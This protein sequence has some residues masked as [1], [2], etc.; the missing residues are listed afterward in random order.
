MQNYKAN[1]LYFGIALPHPVKIPYI[2]Q[3]VAYI[4]QNAAKLIDPGL[5]FSLY[6]EPR[7]AMSPLLSAMKTASVE[8]DA[9]ENLALERIIKDEE[10]SRIVEK[11][12]G[13]S[14]RWKGSD[15]LIEEWGAFENSA[16]RQKYYRKERDE[17]AFKT[18]ALHNFEFYGPFFNYNDLE[19][20]FVVEC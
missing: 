4:L 11:G 7:G 15:H 17:V 13:L 3:P 6:D 9:R 10:F 5:E 16:E 12:D 18:G 1:D 14:W 8:S 19:V 20:R 2:L